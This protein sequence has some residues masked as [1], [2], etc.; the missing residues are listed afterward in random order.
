MELD[1]AKNALR[2]AARIKS[3]FTANMSHEL[4]TPEWVI[5]FYPS[6]AQKRAEH[7]PSVTI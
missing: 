2:R 7:R 6:D 5:G 4:R 3:E 1:L